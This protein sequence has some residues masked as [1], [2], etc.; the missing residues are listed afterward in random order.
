MCQ[1]WYDPYF[2]FEKYHS[3]YAV[4]EGDITGANDAG[5]ANPELDTIVDQ[6]AEL[7]YDMYGSTRSRS[8]TTMPWSSSSATRW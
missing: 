8:S 4:P 7:P 2:M 5:Y 3:K 6:L 1:T